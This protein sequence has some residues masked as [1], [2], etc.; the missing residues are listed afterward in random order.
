MNNT[1][2]SA[3]KDIRTR[4]H[5]DASNIIW[6]GN[7]PGGAARFCAYYMGVVSE[8]TIDMRYNAEAIVLQARDEAKRIHEQ[9][10]ES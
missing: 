10:T 1:G 2:N 6:E 9:E 7:I 8:N 5:M 4:V 3:M